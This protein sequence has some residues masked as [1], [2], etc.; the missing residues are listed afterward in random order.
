MTA[1]AEKP[2]KSEQKRINLEKPWTKKRIIASKKKIVKNR[3]QKKVG[4]SWNKK[5]LWKTLNKKSIVF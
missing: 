5:E 4:I 3:K 2:K 1:E